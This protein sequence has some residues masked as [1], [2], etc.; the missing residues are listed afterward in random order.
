[1]LPHTHSHNTILDRFRVDKEE[2]V[3]LK[4][5]EYDINM[6]TGFFKMFLRELPEPV[7]PFEQYA[8]V[9]SAISESL[10]GEVGI[11]RGSQKVG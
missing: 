6:L 8:Q 4:D 9:E 3:N 1:M 11:C 10:S 2:P 7:I 5:A